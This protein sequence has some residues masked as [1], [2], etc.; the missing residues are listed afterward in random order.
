VKREE[1]RKKIALVSSLCCS[2][3]KNENQTIE[4]RSQTQGK[5]KNEGGISGDWIDGTANGTKIVRGKCRSYC[6]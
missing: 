2:L 5:V 6:L 4:K 1:S 3:S